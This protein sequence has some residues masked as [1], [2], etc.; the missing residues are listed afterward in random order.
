[1][2]GTLHYQWQLNGTNIPGASGPNL[3]LAAAG[4]ADAGDYS[5]VLTDANGSTSVDVGTMGVTPTDA[6]LVNFSAMADIASGATLDTGF[7]VSSPS[8]DSENL[9]VS[10]IG[11]SLEAFG[12]ANALAAPQ[13]TM[14]SAPNSDG[15]SLDD[16]VSQAFA[17]G[18]YTAQLSGVGSASGVGMTEVDDADALS[19]SPSDARLVNFSAAASVGTSSSPF[20]VGFAI[21]A[22]PS[23]A[24]ET[25]LLRAVG[26]TLAS[27][28]VAAPLS[29]TVLTVYDAEGNIIATNAGWG[30]APA[31]GNSTVPAGVE[32]ASAG[33]MDQLGA[34]SLPVGSADSALVVTLPPG[35][36][37][38]EISGVSA[39][40]GTGLAEIYE[41][42]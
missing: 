26:P 24:S 7:V 25:V 20:L 42:R 38:L 35:V 18:T 6:S 15:S 14:S 1:M 21:G 39:G 8:G 9:L 32:P 28:G 27:L 29:A 22:G 19:G 16:A 2:T 4:A 3:A 33:L 11:P 10:A 31:A 5:V 12:I 40:A 13:L 37:S 41:I 17:P 30:N 23:G 34:F 36:Y